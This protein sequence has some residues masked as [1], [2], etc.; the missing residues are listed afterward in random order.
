LEEFADR[1]LYVALDIKETTSSFDLKEEVIL[2]M[3]N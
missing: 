1:P 2:T 3:L